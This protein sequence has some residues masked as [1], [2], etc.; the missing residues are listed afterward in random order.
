LHSFSPSIKGV[1]GDEPTGG[2]MQNDMDDPKDL[3]QPDEE[4]LEDLKAPAEDQDE[5][6]GGCA[7]LSCI[8]TCA[9][10]SDSRE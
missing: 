9:A 2:T 8:A 1:A 4:E 10:A 3:K 5:V 6:E 7:V